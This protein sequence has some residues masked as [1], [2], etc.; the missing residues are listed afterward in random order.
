MTMSNKQTLTTSRDEEVSSS[1]TYPKEY[2]GPKS[3]EEQIK[4]I[5][6]IFDL[7][8]TRALEY[9]K[10]L[11]ELPEG[12]EG[13][14]A[15]PSVDALAKKHFPEVTDSSEKYCRAVQLVHEKIAGSREFS[16][17]RNGKITSSHLRVHARTAHAF[18]LIAENQPG[19]ILV[20]AAQLGVNYRGHSVRQAR[21]AFTEN[22]FGLTSL[23]VG[24]I[25]LTHPMR[26]VRWKELDMDCPGDEFAPDADGDFSFAPLFFNDGKVLFY[27]YRVDLAY[28]RYGSASGFVPQ[29]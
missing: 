7:D 19:D 1:Y 24:S 8:S 27:A 25:V 23:A 20:I 28:D 14:F 2:N 15:I 21:K 29:S 26:L 3:I 16:N 9:T 10:N 18:D 12:A 13:W 11:P 5:A 22:E 4:A 17:Y 6:E